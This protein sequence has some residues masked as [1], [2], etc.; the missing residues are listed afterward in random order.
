MKTLQMAQDKE[1]S[2][3]MTDRRITAL[4][5]GMTSLFLFSPLA[6][7]LPLRSKNDKQKD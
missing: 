5:L 3:K 2:N 7:R 4:I 6:R 1:G